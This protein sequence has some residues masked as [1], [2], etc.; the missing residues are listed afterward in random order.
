MSEFQKMSKRLRIWLLVILGILILLAVTLPEKHLFS[1]MAL[2]LTIGLYNL[3]LLQRKVWLQG[4]A[5]V[6]EGK[7]IGT[8]S[9][10]RFAAAALGAIIAMRLDWSMIGYII[11][12]MTIYPVI[13]IGFFWHT[14]NQ[15]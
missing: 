9:I 15:N 12:I 2:G 11:G 4:E 8:G 14:R 3:W 7:R 6:R 1:G 10:S 5:A 13:I